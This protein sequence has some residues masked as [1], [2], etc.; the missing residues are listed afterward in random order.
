LDIRQIKK[1]ID[2][3]SESDLSEIEVR[4]GEESVRLSRGMHQAPVVT[5]AVAPPVVAGAAGT[6]AQEEQGEKENEDLKNALCSPMVGTFYK[7]PSPDAE[8]F[9]QVGSQV[10]K[11]DVVCIIEAMKMMNRIEADKSGTVKS[12]LVENSDPVEFGQ[13][14]LTIA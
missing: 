6:G 3:L 2:L 11:G 9:V 12:I 5:H 1:L 13:P 14:L 10:S 7:A 4:S 8:P